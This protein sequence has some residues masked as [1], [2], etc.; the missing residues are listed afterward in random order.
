MLDVV[1]DRETWGRGNGHGYGTLWKSD[2]TKCCLG[3]ACLAVGL[4]KDDIYEESTPAEVNQAM[5]DSQI[6]QLSDLLN[7]YDFNKYTDSDISNNLMAVN[8]SKDITEEEREENIVDLGKKAGI[9]F[10]FVN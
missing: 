5:N 2:D 4:V 1:I 3:F 8:D 9:N 6:G 7:V 10:T